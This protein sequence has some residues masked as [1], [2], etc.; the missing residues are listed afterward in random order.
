VGELVS[1]PTY[2]AYIFNSQKNAEEQNLNSF[3]NDTTDLVI[4]EVNGAVISVIAGIVISFVFIAIG[5]LK[6][7]GLI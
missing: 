6:G 2:F 4:S 1:I 5:I 3:A 7:L